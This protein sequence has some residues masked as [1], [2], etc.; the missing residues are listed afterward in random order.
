MLMALIES[1]AVATSADWYDTRHLTFKKGLLT[2][3]ENAFVST[4]LNDGE[5]RSRFSIQQNIEGIDTVDRIQDFRDNRRNE[6]RW[7]RPEEISN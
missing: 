3:T 2:C 7:I 4:N 1:S 6:E 5:E